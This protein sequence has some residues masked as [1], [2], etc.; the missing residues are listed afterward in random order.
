MNVLVLDLL[1]NRVRHKHMVKLLGVHIE[2]VGVS[3]QHVN[4][5]R[6]IRVLETGDLGV[7]L[8]WLGKCE[9]ERSVHV[10]SHLHVNITYLVEVASGDDTRI[11]VFR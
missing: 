8:Q 4:L 3:L 5:V 1:C 9:L 2:Q 10:S 7:L 6:S 11:L